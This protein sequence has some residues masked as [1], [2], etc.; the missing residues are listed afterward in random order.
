MIIQCNKYTGFR[1]CIYISTPNFI[2]KD[3]ALFKNNPL[4]VTN[5]IIAT[6]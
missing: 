5:I 4:S 1:R 6:L 2:T 3:A